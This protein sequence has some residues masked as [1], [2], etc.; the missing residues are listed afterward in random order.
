MRAAVTGDAAALTAAACWAVGSHLFGRIGRGGAVPPGAMNLGKLA[1]ATVLFGATLLAMTGRLWPEA[2]RG[3]L[4]LLAAS[5]AVGLAIGDSAYF[6]AIVTIG[7]RR[8]ILLLSTAPVFTAIGGA[9]WLGERLGV[10]DVMA[11]A[12]VLLGLV[13]V[14]QD[15][16]PAREA[17]RLVANAAPRP[18]LGVGVLLGL[19]AGLGQA[20]GSLLSRAAMR[21]GIDAIS[22]SHVR[23]VSGLIALVLLAAASRRLVPW[24]RA[25]ASQRTLGAVAGS[26]TIGTYAGIWLAQ[27]AIG[28]A[29]STAIASTLLATAPLFALPLGR[30]LNAERITARAVGGTLV[31][32]AGLMTL[33][34][35]G[36]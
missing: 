27:L 13:L 30:V 29:S 5:G 20:V 18:H 4:L 36:R 22:A 1:T 23:I 19:C 25:L 2:Q 34:M 12:A 32:S 26:A 3:A 7:V 9:V 8:S 31:A 11:I 17:V 15:R 28:T 35:L 24:V 33:A 16:E 14:V 6:G 10:V 21:S